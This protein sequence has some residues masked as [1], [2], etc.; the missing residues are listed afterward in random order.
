MAVGPPGAVLSFGFEP[1]PRGTVPTGLSNVYIAE[2]SYRCRAPA[3]LF[4]VFASRL[5][6]ASGCGRAVMELH[7]Q[8]YNL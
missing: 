7:N 3:P 5:R 4:Q 8:G 1:L 6:R 2:S